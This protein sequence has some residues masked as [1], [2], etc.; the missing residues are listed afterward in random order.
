MT[1][2]TRRVTYAN[3]ASTLA[4]VVALGGG[5]AY[6]A[7]LAKNSVASKQIKNGTIKAVDLKADSVTS[8]AVAN[9]SLTSAD[10]AP[11]AIPAS[12]L[13]GHV[14]VRL[15]SV[16]LPQGPSAGNPGA[17]TSTFATCNAGEQI[18]GGSANI[19]N[20]ADPA[21]MELLATRPSKDNVGNGA[22][23]AD[24]EAF[25]FWKGTART[26][27]NNISPAPALRVFAICW[28]P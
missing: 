2:R 15:V 21:T 11:G 27:T 24:G 9:S 17:I 3:L 18:I 12:T 8:A 13:V 4:L 23:P 20:A 14:R 6:A 16:D 28:Y 26:L 25:S 10:L 22:V 1:Q 7:G 19:S 5:G